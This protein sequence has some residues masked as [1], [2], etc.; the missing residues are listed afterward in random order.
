MKR[1]IRNLTCFWYIAIVLFFIGFRRIWKPTLKNIGSTPPPPPLAGGGFLGTERW[2]LNHESFI[3]PTTFNLYQIVL[4]IFGTSS[5]IIHSWSNLLNFYLRNSMTL[6]RCLDLA[7]CACLN[8]TE[9]IILNLS[10]IYR[11][12]QACLY[13]ISIHSLNMDFFCFIFSI[14]NE[15]YTLL[16]IAKMRSHFNPEFNKFIIYGTKEKWVR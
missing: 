4:I 3:K 16:A 8:K 15:W 11:N 7:A 5:I 14:I 6:P 12:Q 13:H 10:W 1:I 2:E 9:N